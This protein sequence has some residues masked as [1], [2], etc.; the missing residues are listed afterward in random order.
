MW[1]SLYGIFG[2]CIL[3][4]KWQWKEEKGVEQTSE[5]AIFQIGPLYNWDIW[6]GYTN[7]VV[8]YFDFHSPQ[9]TAFLRR[10]S[11]RV[12]WQNWHLLSLIAECKQ[13]KNKRFKSVQTVVM[14]VKVNPRARHRK[15]NAPPQVDHFQHAAVL[16][17]NDVINVDYHEVNHVIHLIWSAVVV[18]LPSNLDINAQVIKQ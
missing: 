6:S 17:Y 10:S 1:Y 12:N 9:K 7:R 2:F 16:N 13:V 4:C 3:E 11:Q 15:Q 14:A 8:H 18:S 5:K